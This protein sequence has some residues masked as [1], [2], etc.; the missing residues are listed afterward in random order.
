MPGLHAHEHCLK[1]ARREDGTPWFSDFP[2]PV[3]SPKKT[4]PETV[5]TLIRQRDGPDQEK[6]HDFLLIDN[7]RTDCIGGTI[8]GSLN[9]PAHS[10]YLSRKILYD[11]CRQASVKRIIFYCGS[12]NGR[13]P[14]CA[15]WMQDYIDSVQDPTE[16]ARLE[17]QVMTGGI[18]GWIKAYKGDM[19]EG[20]DEKVWQAQMNRPDEETR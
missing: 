19:M 16:E 1:M 4:S 13:G 12:S 20:Y 5:A 8:V 9:L 7:R 3:S 17:A 2:E 14:R 11:L 15:A 6:P 18:R 10:F